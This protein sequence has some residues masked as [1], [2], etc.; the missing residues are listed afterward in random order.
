MHMGKDQVADRLV[1]DG[2]DRREQGLPM[3]AGC[4]CVDYRD[5]VIPH[6]KAQVG[7]PA[8]RAV[9]ELGHLADVNMDAIGHL[10]HRQGRQVVQIRAGQA[11]VLQVGPLHQPVAGD[12]QSVVVALGQGGI[13]LADQCHRGADLRIGGQA[14]G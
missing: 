3:R 1:A 5:A 8:V 14:G 6:H 12:S 2:P 9:L 7:D 4:A 10:V 13:W 11:A